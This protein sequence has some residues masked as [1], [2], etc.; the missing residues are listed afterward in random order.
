[1]E[2][3]KIVLMNLFVRQQWRCRHRKQT[4][5]HKRMC[6]EW[7]EYHDNIYTT[8]CK[9]DSQWDLLY[10]S[11]S[12]NLC[13]VTTYWGGMEWEVGGRFKMEGTY[14][15]LWLIHVVW[16]SQTKYCKAIILQLKLNKLKKNL[17]TNF[18]CFL[19]ASRQWK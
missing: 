12:W 2:S 19:Q 4:C 11:G 10:G 5:G 9:I 13:S 3:R 6:N 16:Q 14:V 7:R 18:F 15:Y 1:M 8:I 17:R